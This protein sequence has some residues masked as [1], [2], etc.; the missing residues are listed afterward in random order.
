M[1]RK[2]NVANNK[3]LDRLF[4]G[5]N[6]Q[7]VSQGRLAGRNT[8]SHDWTTHKNTHHSEQSH[9]CYSSIR[10][11]NVWGSLMRQYEQQLYNHMGAYPW[12][13]MGTTCKLRLKSC[14][15]LRQESFI[16]N[17]AFHIQHTIRSSTV[18]QAH[19]IQ[20]G[21]AARW[22]KCCKWYSCKNEKHY[23]CIE[24]ADPFS[25]LLFIPFLVLY[26]SFWL[27]LLANIQVLIGSANYKCHKVRKASIAMSC[28]LTPQHTQLT[29]SSCSYVEKLHQCITYHFNEI[30][31]NIIVRNSY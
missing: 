19:C 13:G 15:L 25:T 9:H 23:T 1:L 31:I 3:E 24:A 20:L 4:P 11:E 18:N 26:F 14:S 27:L 17:S 10:G 5:A 28:D 22:I 7:R 30:V 6:F 29:S 8:H 21:E 12:F 2:K 16:N